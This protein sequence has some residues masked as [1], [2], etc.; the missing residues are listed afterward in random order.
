MPP[1]STVQEVK[2]LLNEWLHRENSCLDSDVLYTLCQENTSD[3]VCVEVLSCSPTLSHGHLTM[4]REEVK[5]TESFC[6]LIL[7]FFIWLQLYLL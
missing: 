1:S 2:L 5:H 6:T 4:K 7:L 3:N